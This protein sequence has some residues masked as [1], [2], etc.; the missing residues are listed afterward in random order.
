MSSKSLLFILIP[1]SIIFSFT[2]QAFSKKLKIRIPLYL[3]ITSFFFII[4]AGFSYLFFVQEVMTEISNSLIVENISISSSTLFGTF[5]F[6]IFL[7]LL[8]LSIS[9]TNMRKTG[10]KDSNN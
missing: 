6:I 5:G 4:L 10:S 2:I 3:Q 7:I 1:L 9:I 8:G